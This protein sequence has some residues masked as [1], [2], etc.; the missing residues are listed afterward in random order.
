MGVFP[1]EFTTKELLV[2]L[3]AAVF[4]TTVFSILD[5]VYGIRFDGPILFSAKLAVLLFVFYPIVRSVY[6]HFGLGRFLS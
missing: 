6:L 1:T 5:F 3:A 2:F 4:H